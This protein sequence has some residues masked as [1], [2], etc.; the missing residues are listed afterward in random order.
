MTTSGSVSNIFV[1]VLFA[2]VPQPKSPAAT[3]LNSDSFVSAVPN[4]YFTKIP[5]VLNPNETNT[6]I[7]NRKIFFLKDLKLENKDILHSSYV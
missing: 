6:T 2:F 4:V 5:N 7:N 3:K 1:I